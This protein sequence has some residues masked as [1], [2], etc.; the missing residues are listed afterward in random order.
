MSELVKIITATDPAVRD[1]PLESFCEP[2]SLETLWG[3]RYAESFLEV[4]NG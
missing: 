4:C 3:D 1:R 2:A